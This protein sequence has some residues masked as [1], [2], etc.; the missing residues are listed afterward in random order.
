[1]PED[2]S[3][4]RDFSAIRLKLAS[5]DAI[6]SWSHGEVTKPETINYRTQKPEKSGLF[7][8]EIFGPTKDWECYCGK[9]KRIRYKGIVCDKCG[10]EVT[11]ALV[12]RERMGHIELAA[13][14]SHIWFLRGVPSK[15]GLSLDLSIME[16]EKVIYF[17]AFIV[18]KV[19]EELR[20]DT[21]KQID[22]E[23]DAKR[24]QIEADAQRIANEIQS[25][26]AKDLEAA[27]ENVAKKERA[28]KQ[29]TEALAA[30]AARKGERLAALETA[31]TVAKK[32]LT[33]LKPR[34]IIAESQYHDLSLKYGHVFEAGIGAEAIHHLLRGLSL[35]DEI[36]AL[37]AE[38]K[39][40]SEVKQRK[41]IRRLK[42]LK[43]LQATHL[44]PEWMVLTNIPIIP[45][46]LR[47]MVQLD[48]GRFAASD[49]NDLYRR[50]INRNN[51]LKRLLELNAPEVITR[52]EKRMLQEAVD[53][54]ID[55]GARHGKTVTAATGQ[56]RQL[57]SIADMLKGKQGRFRQNLLGK[58]V[59]YSGRSVIVVGPHLQL[60]QC[61]LPKRMALELFKPFVIA[62]LIKREYVHNVR[63]ANRFIES[64]RSE[65]WDIVEEITKNSHVLLN[66]APTLHRLGIQAFQPVLIEGKAIQLH[67]M[68]C[69]AFNADFDGDQMAVHVPLTEAAK[70]EAAELMLSSKNLLKPATGTPVVTPSQDIVLGCYYLTTLKPSEK[71]RSFVSADEAFMALAAGNIHLHEEIIVRLPAGKQGRNGERLQTSVGRLAFNAVLPESWP[72]VNTHQDKKSLS[73]MVGEFIQK[74]GVD[75]TVQTIDKLKNI[76]FQYLTSSGISWGMG[77]LN[78]PTEKAEILKSADAKVDELT[79]NYEMGLLTDDE[80]HNRII[81]VWDQAKVAIQKA[82][83][84]T[85]DPFGPV[86]AMIESGARGSWGQ[87]TQMMGMKG[88]VTNPAGDIIELPVR[89]SFKEGFDVLEYFISTHGARKGLSDTALRTANA[90]YLTRRLIDVAQD[91]VISEPQCADDVGMPLKKEDSELLGDSVAH[92]ALGRTSLQRIA[93]PKTKKV[94]VNKNALITEDVVAALEPLDLDELRI[95]TVLTCKTKRGLCAACYGYDLGHNTQVALGTAVGIIAAQ[96]IGEPGTQLTMRTFHTGGVAGHDITQGLPRVEELFEARPVKKAAILATAT[97][98]ISIVEGEKGEKVLKLTF[99]GQ[100]DDVYP[101]KRG[102]K[103]SVKEGQAVRKGETLAEAKGKDPVTALESGIATLQASS[104]TIRREAE[105]VEEFTAHPGDTILVKDGD[106]VNVGQQLTDGSLDLHQLYHLQGEAAVQAY[107]I[108]ETQF[109]YS[110]QGQKLNDKHIEVIVRQMFSRV[111]I[112]DNGDTDLIAGEIIER[113]QYEEANE[114]AAAKN[115]ELAKGEILLYGITKASLSIDSFLSAASFQETA[116]VL[117]DAAVSGKVDRLRG[118]KE[119]VIIGKLIPAGTGYRPDEPQKK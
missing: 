7:A 68:V 66:R 30:N 82:C 40:A 34:Q 22:A 67:P 70:K 80:R 83:K 25:T 105:K 113:A 65:V 17:A 59:D 76:S 16:L 63:S 1:M 15:I 57:K 54:L 86:F 103:A 77:D 14:V 38:K 118:L 49:L 94:I 23:L 39:T 12:R 109:I 51:R 93:D 88:L 73:K 3:T 116:R 50:V 106:L 48:G 112:I 74:L 31:A 36:K 69:T 115:K 99:R 100:M 5:P 33:T 55:N 102:W 89:G 28:D 18:T 21:L 64:D 92:R 52:N 62:Q 78:I 104:I 27:K 46:D 53:A 75:A 110:S 6:R 43:S 24:K 71:P 42:L 4:L 45:P 91:I 95:R 81:E 90:G 47:P 37:E 8:E 41:A 13:P 56:K 84:L 26:R 9:Y 11:R 44:R 96:S 117:I 114:K 107:L 35:D 61:G 72:Y 97:G 32:E 87:T 58:R 2:T 111:Y 60:H 29:A 101:I 20:Q 108:K 85:L 98:T 119:N 10:V 19:N 79:Q